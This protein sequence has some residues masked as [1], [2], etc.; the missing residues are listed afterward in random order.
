MA[1]V[2]WNILGV[3][4]GVVEPLSNSANGLSFGSTVAKV[5]PSCC[6]KCN[7]LDNA[8]GK[9]CGLWM[10]ALGLSNH[11]VMY[12]SKSSAAVIAAIAVVA[13]ASR[14]CMSLGVG[15]VALIYAANLHVSKAM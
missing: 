7:A 3:G 6:A 9:I 11:V 8:G 10:M 5:G 1:V 2:Y 13:V 15:A 4:G 14:I 12:A